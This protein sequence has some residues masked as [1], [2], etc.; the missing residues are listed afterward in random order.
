MS[1]QVRK[2]AKSP[3]VEQNGRK[4]AQVEQAL[5][6]LVKFRQKQKLTQ[7]YVAKRMGT[8]QSVI[9][10]LEAKR[11]EKGADILFST[12][13]RYAKAVGG[14]IAIV[15][16]TDEM[17]SSAAQY[18]RQIGAVI[19]QQARND[20]R[21]S[22]EVQPDPNGNRAARRRANKKTRKAAEQ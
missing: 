6:H 16:E 5:G 20:Y 4:V 18:N 9:S 14:K 22:R 8:Y 1:P 7:Q 11:E 13:V 2:G 19:R 21:K 3:M 17:P 15:V 12:L 10:E